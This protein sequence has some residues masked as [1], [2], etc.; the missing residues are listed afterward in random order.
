MLIKQADR[1]AF[2]YSFC[3][4]FWQASEGNP[5]SIDGDLMWNVLLYF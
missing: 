2:K 5:I 3:L 4:L 1:I